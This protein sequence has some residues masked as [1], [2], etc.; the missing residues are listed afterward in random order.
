MIDDYGG[1]RWVFRDERNDCRVAA[2]RRLKGREFQIV[3][4]AKEK[5][6]RPADDLRKG[7]VSQ[8]LSEER[9]LRAGV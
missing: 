2:E 9:R 3:G 7:T 5:E 4:A 6:R 8:S 1:K